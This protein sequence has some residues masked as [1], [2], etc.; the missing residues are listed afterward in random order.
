MHGFPLTC[1]CRT[2]LS[3]DSACHRQQWY[4]RTMGLRARPIGMGLGLRSESGIHCLRQE[5]TLH[6]IGWLSAS[7]RRR[8]VACCSC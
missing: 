5:V 2:I 1:T 4:C 6:N 8:W 7:M 3:L